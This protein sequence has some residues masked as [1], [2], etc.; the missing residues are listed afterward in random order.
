MDRVTGRCALGLFLSVL[1]AGCAPTLSTMDAPE[2]TP[3]TR[4][5]T[6]YLEVECE[7]C[8]VHQLD[9]RVAASVIAAVPG[10]RRLSDPSSAD[11]TIKYGQGDT[12]I[13]LDCD[14]PRFWSWSAQLYI[15]RGPMELLFAMLSGDV[16]KFRGKP[17]PLFR[18]QFLAYAT[19]HGWTTYH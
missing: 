17:G 13:C 15:H 7:H 3:P 11:V 16:D 9:G 6:Y 19:T 4:V 2:A 18:K 12:S 8:D 14:E 5:A 10:A 1:T